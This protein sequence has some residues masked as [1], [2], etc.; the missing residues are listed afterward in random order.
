MTSRHLLEQFGPREAMAYDVVIVGAG[1]AGARD[2][3]SSER[4]ERGIVGHRSGKRGSEPGAHTLFGAVMDP[5]QNT[6]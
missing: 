2:R 1:R 6:V 5:M 3:N 4:T